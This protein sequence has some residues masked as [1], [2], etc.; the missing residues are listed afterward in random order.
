MKKAE[1]MCEWC[2]RYLADFHYYG[3]GKDEKI[4]SCCLITKSNRE[5]RIKQVKVI[6]EKKEKK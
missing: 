5:D 4:C 6:K 1:I 2:D 3:N